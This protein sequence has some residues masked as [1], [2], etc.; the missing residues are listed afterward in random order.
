M[1]SPH[2]FTTWMTVAAAATVAGPVAGAAARFE[3]NPA[4]QTR[5]AVAAAPRVDLRSPDARDAASGVY[6]SARSV[7]L[8]SP[9]ARGAATGHGVNTGYQPPVVQFVGV[10]ASHGFDWGDAGI[11]AGGALAIVLLLAGGTM[12]ATHRKGQRLGRS[13]PSALAR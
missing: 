4:Q 11:G 6:P 10:G 8:R 9:D 5:P 7:D 2:R 13:G 1:L 3:L 12:I